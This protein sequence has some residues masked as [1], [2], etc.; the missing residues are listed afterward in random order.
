MEVEKIPRSRSF[1]LKGRGG[2]R[3]KEINEEGEAGRTRQEREGDR[4]SQVLIHP[5]VASENEDIGSKSRSLNP[6]TCLGSVLFH[7]HTSPTDHF[8]PVVQFYTTPPV[9]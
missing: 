8:Y 4:E 3:R 7:F 9:Q 1:S 2:G 5:S 6:F